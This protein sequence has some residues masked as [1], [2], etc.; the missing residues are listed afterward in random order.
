M[1]FAHQGLWV[2]GCKSLPTNLVDPKEYGISGVMGYQVHG[3]REFQLYHHL[4]STS[5]SWL[6]LTA[7]EV[8]IISTALHSM[9]S[10]TFGAPT[11]IWQD[12]EAP[13]V[14]SAA[15]V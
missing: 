1:G 9:I 4:W 13:Q 6:L 12:P 8:G 15:K 3:L 14:A 2:M 5:E 7:V 10:F 11:A